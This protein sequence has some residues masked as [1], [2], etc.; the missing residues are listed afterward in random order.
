MNHKVIKYLKNNLTVYTYIQYTQY[1][2]KI[3]NTDK[4]KTGAA[5]IGTGK[6]ARTEIRYKGSK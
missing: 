3:V 4:G 2:Y 5:R 1:I 6:E